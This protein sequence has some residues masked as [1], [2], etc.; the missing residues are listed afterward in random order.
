MDYFAGLNISMDETHVCVLD[1]EG[2]IIYESKVS[3]T[4][5]A[6]SV[7]LAKA[8]NCHRAVFE[9]GRTAPILFHGLNQLG[10]PVVCVESRQ[11]YQ[12]LKSLVTHKT[13]RNDARAGASGSHWLLQARACEVAAGS[14]T[15]LVDRRAQETG[16]RASDPGKP[17]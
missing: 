14:C 6:I 10:L 4:A 9:T 16:R 13:D 5:E 12:A 11:A 3:S 17:N 15:A 2:V 1:R 7:E 8:P